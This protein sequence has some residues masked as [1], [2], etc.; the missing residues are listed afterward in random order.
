VAAAEAGEGGLGAM[1]GA[2][3]G[4]FGLAILA[5]L[6]AGRSLAAT[7]RHSLLNVLVYSVVVAGSIYVILDFELPRVGLIR[8]D[9]TDRLLV[10]LLQSMN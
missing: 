3:Y 1:D 10:A 2:V 8:E 9:L 4:L 6:L 5:S 7:P